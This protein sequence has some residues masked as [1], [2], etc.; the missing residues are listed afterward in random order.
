M[1]LSGPG[2]P[3]LKEPRSHCAWRECHE[4][5]MEETAAVQVVQ[6]RELCEPRTVDPSPATTDPQNL[7]TAEKTFNLPENGPKFPTRQEG[8]LAQPG[9][10]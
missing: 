9:F 8:F 2:Q 1:S 10:G 6:R 4:M 3:R 5:R 7:P